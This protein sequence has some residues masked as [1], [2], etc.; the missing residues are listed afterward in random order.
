MHR[1]NKLLKGEFAVLVVVGQAPYLGKQCL[2]EAR[3]H[4]KGFGLL[5]CDVARAG[6]VVALKH[7]RIFHA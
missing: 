5:A 4:K 7:L 6:R 3:L 2:G 1:N